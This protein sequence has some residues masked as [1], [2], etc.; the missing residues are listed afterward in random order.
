MGARRTIVTTNSI[1]WL[2]W[3]RLLTTSS[4]NVCGPTGS[5]ASITTVGSGLSNGL[6]G[7]SRMS[8]Y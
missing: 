1:G 4:R 8:R 6:P 7:S 5:P 3:P 2:C